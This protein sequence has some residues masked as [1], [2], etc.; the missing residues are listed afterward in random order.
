MAKIHKLINNCMSCGKIVCQK[1]GE[2]PCTFC[3]NFVYSKHGDKNKQSQQQYKKEMEGDFALYK[4]Y[5]EAMNFKEK[6]LDYDKSQIASKNIID[7][8][9]DWYEIQQDVWQNKKIRD[10]ALAKV[11]QLEAEEDEA[12][13]YIGYDV[14]FK[15]GEVKELKKTL[16]YK[17]KK[18]EA[19]NYIIDE[20]EQERKKNRNL[21]MSQKQT[22]NIAEQKVLNGI[23]N[24]LDRAY[25]P[26]ESH[27]TRK[28]KNPRKNVIQHDDVFENL[29]KY[30]KIANKTLLEDLKN[31]DQD[32]YDINSASDYKCLTFRQ[33]F[34]SLVV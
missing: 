23:K 28:H 16:D 11:Q 2:G 18:N 24:Q 32:I 15:T 34:A 1:E 7:E 8:E 31:F 4:E 29:V 10:M 14:N 6:L 12:K 3:G 19:R 21:I 20:E 22:N 33:P 27:R 17:A 13:K 26:S 25:H 9:T 30:D 5:T